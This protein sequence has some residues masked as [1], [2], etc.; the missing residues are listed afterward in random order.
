MRRRRQ[1]RK[2]GSNNIILKSIKPREDGSVSTERSYVLE[3]GVTYGDVE[4]IRDTIP[5]VEIIVPGRII[6]KHVWNGPHRVD[7]EI[8]GTAPWYQRMRR[9]AV[10]EGRFFYGAGKRRRRGMWWC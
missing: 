6:R 4:R 2:L 8:I 9:L 10:M 3:Y 7:A 1:I 5:G